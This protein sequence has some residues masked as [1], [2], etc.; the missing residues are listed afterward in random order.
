MTDEQALIDNMPSNQLGWE[1]YMDSIQHLM[2]GLTCE[3]C[4]YYPRALVCPK[5]CTELEDC[6]PP[7][8]D[9]E[10]VDMSGEKAVSEHKPTHTQLDK[11]LKDW[12]E[13]MK[14]VLCCNICQ[15]LS[16]SAI[17]CLT[18]LN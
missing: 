11:D 8:P 12:N 1:T 9:S 10:R 2:P 4:G 16:S 18:L 6:R 17:M 7:K 3:T 13:S 15:C 14:C 5:L